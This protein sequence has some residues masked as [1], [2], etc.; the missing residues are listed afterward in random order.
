MA[1]AVSGTLKA[2]ACFWWFSFSLN[3]HTHKLSLGCDSR[4]G[5]FHSAFATRNANTTGQTHVLLTAVQPFHLLIK[6]VTPGLN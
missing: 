1:M 6:L 5:L 2:L 4:P 3:C